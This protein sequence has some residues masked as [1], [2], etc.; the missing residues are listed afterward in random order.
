MSYRY[1][2]SSSCTSCFTIITFTSMIFAQTEVTIVASKDNTLYESATGANS[3]GA[4][5]DFFV[6]NNRTGNTRRGL[7]AFDIASNIP[8]GGSI[9]SVR[10]T[11]HL[12]KTQPG[13]QTISLHRVL[14]DWGEGTS[15]ASDP[16]GQGAPSTTGDATW[17]HRFF[18]TVLWTTPG[19]DFSPT[20]SANQ[21]VGDIGSY[22]WGSTQQMVADVQNWLDNPSQNFGWILLGNESANQTAK[23]FDTKENPAEGNRP[24]LTVTFLVTNVEDNRD[25]IPLEFSLAQNYPNPFNPSTKISWQS[26]VGSWLTLKVYDVLGNEVAS[27]VDE[28]KQAGSYE[29]E[30]DASKLSS[31][32][33]AK[34]GYASGVYFYRI[35]AGSFNQVKKMILLR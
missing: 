7:V 13:T 20:A 26:S 31:G 32:V 33:S 5:A 9:Q 24:V 10:L 11:L 23:R 17:I 19:G 18:D 30:F 15:N 6:G 25:G 34:G 12:S 4:G 3:N 27:L 22:T 14:A 35:Q 8:A 29:V 1:F 2:L 28:F 21:S 16:E